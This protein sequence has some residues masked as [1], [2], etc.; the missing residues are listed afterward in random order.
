M[1][2]ERDFALLWHAEFRR[3]VVA[4]LRRVEQSLNSLQSTGGAYRRGHEHMVSA[5]R[6]TLRAIDALAI[7][8]TEAPINAE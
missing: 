2:G 4:K 8:S 1:S 6:E 7:P 3:D 5:Y